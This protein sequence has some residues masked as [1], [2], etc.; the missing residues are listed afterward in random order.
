MQFVDEAT[1]GE[2]VVR[3][4]GISGIGLQLF[5]IRLNR[6]RHVLEYMHPSIARI[7]H[8]EDYIVFCVRSIW[9]NEDGTVVGKNWSIQR[10]GERPWPANLRFIHENPDFEVQIRLL[11]Y[12]PQGEES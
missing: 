6:D 5:S 4:A 3:V 8:L 1:Q 2:Q 11:E 9:L 10:S 12:I 7:A